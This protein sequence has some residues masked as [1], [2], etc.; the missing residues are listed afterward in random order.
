[1]SVSLLPLL[2][3]GSIGASTTISASDPTS[4]LSSTSCSLPTNR[5][6]AV[7]SWVSLEP[8]TGS[9]SSTAISCIFIAFKD[10]DSKLPLTLLKLL[11]QST[12]SNGAKIATSVTATTKTREAVI[13]CVLDLP[14]VE[15]DIVKISLEASLTNLAETVLAPVE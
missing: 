12:S 1:M 6:F 7:V 14:L 3:S 5:V 8:T 10:A 11:F 2:S 9:C 4:G 13:N 15:F